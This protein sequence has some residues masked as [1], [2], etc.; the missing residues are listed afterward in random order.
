MT[1][2]RRAFSPEFKLHIAQLIRDQ[3]LSIAVHDLLTAYHL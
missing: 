3:G 2:Q 1:K